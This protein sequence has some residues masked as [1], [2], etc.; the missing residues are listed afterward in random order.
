MKNFLIEDNEILDVNERNIIRN[1]IYK[2]PFLY[3]LESTSEKFPYYGHPLCM[4]PK[5]DKTFDSTTKINVVSPHFDFFYK[6]VNRF[7]NKHNIKFTNVIRS[8][9]NSTYYIPGYP[10]VDPHVD[11]SKPHVVLLMYL[12]EVSRASPTLIFNKTQKFDNQNTILDVSKFQNKLLLIKRKIYPKFGKIIAFDGK[13]YH[14]NKVPK[15]GENRIICVFN[16]LI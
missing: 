1:I 8:S 7:C 11:F 2:I 10:Y 9:I 12:N 3:S 16:L 15:P 4:R 14:S 13:Y 6:I 5:F